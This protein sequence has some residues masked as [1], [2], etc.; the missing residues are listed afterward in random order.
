MSNGRYVPRQPDEHVN[1][2]DTHPLAEAGL[3][4]GALGAF[5]VAVTVVI[6]FLVDILVPLISVEREI[7]WL[8]RLRADG[9]I[10]IAASD[11]R[12]DELQALLDGL[13]T[14][15][16]DAGYDF[17]TAIADEQSPNALALPGG[18]IVV[19]SGLL[20]QIESENELAF[21]LGHELGHFN[22]RDHLRQLGRAA[23]LGLMYSTMRS[24]GSIGFNLSDLTLRG[25][26]RD[27]ESDADAFGLQLTQARYGHVNQSWAFFERL[28][29]AEDGPGVVD[30]LATHPRADDRVARIRQLARDNRWPLRGELTPWHADETDT[31][32]D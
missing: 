1:V 8:S 11:P 14:G 18:L 28:G 23:L 10:E 15:W 26:N 30:Y 32:E 21:V 13:L 20:D 19:T 12:S 24:S 16:P 27:Q 5:F 3:L 2:S 31:S 6:V 29:T 7:D 17:R 22:N 9:L 4:F 25:F